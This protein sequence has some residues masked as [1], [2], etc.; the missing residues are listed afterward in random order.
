MPLHVKVLLALV[1]GIVAGVPLHWWWTDATWAALGVGDSA[2]YLAHKTAAGGVGVGVGGEADPNAGAGVAAA[3]ARFVREAGAFAGQFFLRSLRFIAVPVVLFSLIVAVAGV[4]DLRVIGRIGVK[5]LLCF[6]FTLVVAVAIAVLVGRYGAPGTWIDGEAKSVL[7]AKYANPDAVKSSVS[8]AQR[9][10]DQGVSG[11]LM[12]VIPTNPF[13]AIANAEML[14]VVAS[15]FLI[16]VG[17]TMVPREKSQ[18]VTSL[19]EGMTE[20]IMVLVGLIMK[21]APLAVFCLVTQL[22]ASVGLEALRALLAF[23][24]CVVGALSIVLFVEYPLLMLAFTRPGNRMTYGRFFRGMAPAMTLAFSSSSS[25]A[26]LPVTIKCARDGLKVPA[27]IANFVCPMGTTLN[28]DG[29]ALYQVISVLFLAQ[30][31]GVDLTLTQHVTVGIMAC[32]VAVGMPG[33]PGAGIA[34]LAIVLESVNVPTEGVAIILAVDRVLDMCRTIV[35]VSG[36]TVACV[37]VAGS[38]NRLGRDDPGASEGVPEG[39]GA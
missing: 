2:A 21:L 26:T 38:E 11:F 3:G 14:Q 10:K 23:C 6:G 28:M 7:M 13:N 19:C 33:L 32:V 37:V 25:A 4:G 12:N 1:L 24:I 36:D 15:A 18:A 17:L 35:N 31:Y 20:A 27:D 29:S 22:V 34:M 8:T 9:I 5:T 16:G 30:L 39:A